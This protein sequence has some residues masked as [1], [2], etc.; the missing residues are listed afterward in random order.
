MT[1]YYGNILFTALKGRSSTLL[2]V[3]A[4]A[5]LKPDQNKPPGRHTCTA[6]GGCTTRVMEAGNFPF[7]RR[8][9]LSAK[10]PRGL[11]QPDSRSG[12]FPFASSGQGSR[13]RAMLTGGRGETD[14]RSAY[15]ARGP[16]AQGTGFSDPLTQR[17]PL[18]AR[19]RLGDALG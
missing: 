11:G 8:Y 16:A 14:L 7:S 2:S 3:E 4:S 18:S 12:P 17:L 15:A 10:N 1:I 6:E 19:A 13:A 5:G 9:S